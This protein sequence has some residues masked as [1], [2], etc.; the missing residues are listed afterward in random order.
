MKMLRV[1]TDFLN[2]YLQGQQ[3]EA[4]SGVSAV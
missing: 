2:S 3:R 1:K 4:V